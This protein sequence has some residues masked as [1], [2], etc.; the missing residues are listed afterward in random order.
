MKITAKMTILCMIAVVLVGCVSPSKEHLHF[1]SA[2]TASTTN[3]AIQL[4]CQACHACIRNMHRLNSAKKL[5][6]EMNQMSDDDPVDTNAVCVF[7]AGHCLPQCPTAGRYS[8]GKI[9][10]RAGA[11]TTCSIHGSLDA[12]HL[13]D[14]SNPSV[15][16]NVF[17]EGEKYIQDSD[18]LIH[19]P[20][21]FEAG[22]KVC[23]GTV[24]NPTRRKFEFQQRLQHTMIPRI[25]FR[26]T[27]IRTFVEFLQTA[28][29]RNSPQGLPAGDIRINLDLESCPPPLVNFCD[30]HWCSLLDTLKT[31]ADLTDM[32]CYFGED[33]VN[34]TPRYKC[35]AQQVDPQQVDIFAPSS[36]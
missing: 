22:E 17:A 14:G 18:G 16:T 11:T 36:Q 31:L 20:Y 26:D 12:P 30:I 15:V 19:G 24:V 29:R 3:D 27:D 8:F 34:M 6:A 9:G 13:P 10:D 33:F 25:D 35:N 7:L 4:A 32:V 21:R 23:G 1:G 2:R 5:W 28:S